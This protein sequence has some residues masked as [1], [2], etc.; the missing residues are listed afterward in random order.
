MQRPSPRPVAHE[1]QGQ[2]Q[3]GRC[4]A[5]AHPAK[6]DFRDEVQDQA[7]GRLRQRRQR[8]S[9]QSCSSNCSMHLGAYL[10]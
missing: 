8:K 6:A 7:L 9:R 2:D 1:G 5:P 4:N 10:C 3:H